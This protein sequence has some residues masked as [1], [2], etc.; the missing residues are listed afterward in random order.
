MVAYFL[1]LSDIVQAFNELGGEADWT[2][3]QAHVIAK[4]GNSFAPY[5]ALG[6]YKNTMF[7]FVREHCEGYKK[8]KG[9]VRF[10]KI[11]NTRFRLVSPSPAVP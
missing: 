8:L 11:R 10:V 4:R 7:Q 3:V 6:N 2:D 9:D 5:K 1:T